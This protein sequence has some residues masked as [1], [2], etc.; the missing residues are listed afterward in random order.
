MN[1]FT[2][3]A[4]PLVLHNA[5][6]HSH[7]I[8]TW[9]GAVEFQSNSCFL[10]DRFVV[11]LLWYTISVLFHHYKHHC[12]LTQLR[13]SNIEY[14]MPIIYSKSTSYSLCGI[15]F[16]RLPHCLSTIISIPPLLPTLSLGYHFEKIIDFLYSR[17]TTAKCMHG[18]PS[19]QIF[20]V[21]KY[22][23]VGTN[24]FTWQTRLFT[25]TLRLLRRTLP[26]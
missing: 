18:D 10:W 11:R 16:V 14:R 19:S 25:C 7:C 21:A 5:Y 17:N 26:M 24:N 15:S 3:S 12:K 22:T 9:T 4:V 20:L 1:P 13:H 6:I 8:E 23:T 2:D